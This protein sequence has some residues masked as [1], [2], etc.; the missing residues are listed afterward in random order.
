M[1]PH[2]LWP[3]CCSNNGVAP[4][5]AESSERGVAAMAVLPKGV[6]PISARKTGELAR[7]LEEKAQIGDPEIQRFLEAGRIAEY[8]AL[9][10][11][12]SDS[13]IARRLYLPGDEG[14]LFEL[15]PRVINYDEADITKQLNNFGFKDRGEGWRFKRTS[16]GEEE[17]CL[18][19]WSTGFYRYETEN[20]LED[21]ARFR[22]VSADLVDLM[23]LLPHRAELWNRGITYVATGLDNPQRVIHGKGNNNRQV[24]CLVLSPNRKELHARD[25]SKRWKSWHWFLLKKD[26][27]KKSS[28]T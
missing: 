26:G 27:P 3:P 9:I 6:V 18:Y 21:R 7:Q 11:E 14:Q 25:V 16:A 19:L 17:V 24:P 13:I 28:A 2:L 5:N 22:F 8:G 20:I 4:L 12:L 23:Y 1:S 10:T 15:K